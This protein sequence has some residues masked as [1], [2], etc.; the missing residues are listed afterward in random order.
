MKTFILAGLYATLLP[1]YSASDTAVTLPEY[2]SVSLPLQPL[3]NNKGVST[4]GPNST[5]NFDRK[6]GAYDSRFLPRGP[7]EYDG[8]T[9][10]LPTSWDVERDNVIADGQVLRL[11]EPMLVHELHFLY[12]GDGIGPEW[13]SNFTAHFAD[14]SSHQIQLYGK[15]WWMWSNL[16]RGAITTPYHFDVTAAGKNLNTSMIYQWSTS[17]PSESPLESIEFPKLGTVDTL[18]LFALSVTPS[19]THTSAGPALA[20]RRA[21]FTTRWEDIDGVRAQAV[22]VTLANLLPSHT[23]SRHTSI[24]TA[25][26]IEVVGPGI[27]TVVPGVI[28][29]LVPADQARIDVLITGSTANGSAIIQIRDSAG[30]IVSRSRKWPTSPLVKKWTPDPEVLSTHETPSWWNGAKY[31]IFIHWGVYSTPAWAPPTTYAEWYDW[32]IRNPPNSSNPTWDF[33]YD[34]FIPDFTASKFNASAWVDLFDK[35]GAKYFVLVSKHHDGFALFDTGNTSHRNSVV[36]GPKRDLVAELLQTAKAEKPELHRGT[37]YSLPEWFNPDYGKYGFAQWPG[38]LAHNAFN[39]SVLETYTGHVNISDYIDDLQLPQMIEL[40]VTY[41][42]EIMWCDIGGPNRALDFAAAF[43][44]HAQSQ[45][46]Q[47]TINNRCGVVPDFDTPEYATFGSIQTESWESSEGMDPFSYGLNAATQPGRYMNGSTI[48]QTLVDITSKNGNFLLDIGPTAEG[49]IIEPMV[50]GLLDAGAWLDHSGECIYDSEYWF[51]G[52]QDPNPR[53]GTLPPRFLTTPTTF[54]IVAFSSPV[55]GKVTISKRLPLLPDDEITL[56]RPHAPSAP[57]KWDVED[58][59]GKL[60]IDVPASD[61]MA[62]DYAWAFQVKYQLELYKTRIW[63]ASLQ[64]EG[65]FDQ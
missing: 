34:D 19:A 54:C 12:A 59:T 49:E 31:G 29:R 10:A 22:E 24:S 50:E 16:N 20:V 36:M 32:T 44:N 52:S 2:P 18:H 45:G 41:D 40:A 4:T 58:K 8:I 64:G 25:H 39:S 30:H 62:V 46:R 5:A 26:T 9:F 43:Y 33:V 7:W 51:Q 28:N 14:K 35:A 6:G 48:I 42:T 63:M 55:D 3:F 56:L 11:K 17:L 23:L 47:V 60:I 21:R 38:G 53:A 37:Y 61:S 27:K 57:L 1:A 15:N 65:G 13:L